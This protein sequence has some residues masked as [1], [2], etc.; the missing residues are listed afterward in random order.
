MGHRPG[1]IFILI[2]VTLDMLAL[3]IVLPVL[4]RL[5]RE[6]LGGDTAHAAKMVGLFGTAWALMQLLCS[7]LVGAL[8]DRFGR[9]PVALVSNFGQGFDYLVMAAAPTWTWL[10]IGRMVSG[11]T[12]ASV[13]VGGAYI[14][15]ITPKHQR[16]KAFGYLGAAFNLGFIAGPALGGLL[17]NVNPRT[18][19][20]VAGVLSLL[21]A[22]Y[23][24]FVLPESLAAHKRSTW[25]WRSVNPVASFTLL[26][27]HAALVALGC[28]ALLANT[29]SEV[30]PNVTVLYT[31]VRYAWD[32]RTAGMMLATAGLL[33][34]L[35]QAF[36]VSVMVKRLGETRTLQCSLMGGVA[37]FLVYA[38]A[39]SGLGFCL[40]MPLMALSSAYAPVQQSLMTRYIRDDQQGSLQGAQSSL[41]GL[42]GLIGP[43]VFT[44]TFAAAL[45]TNLFIGAPFVLA[46][47]VLLLSVGLARY[48]VHHL[49]DDSAEHAASPS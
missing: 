30:L 18:P 5:V 43:Q 45:E 44:L 27:S 8:S 37:G 21:N 28:V 24:Y 3:G 7:P 35:V 40:G 4:P 39:P 12:A 22:V 38:F 13:S 23:G 20:W 6:M 41:W 34:A 46:A 29:A 47:M 42:A 33:S 2:T 10:F 14:A 15:D 16:A 36:G 25:S 32:A 9:R 48:T 31:D 49:L 1:L 17:G 19:F 11:V 26:R